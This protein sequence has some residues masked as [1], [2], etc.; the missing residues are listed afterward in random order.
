MGFFRS[1]N[2]PGIEKTPDTFLHL[3]NA[4]KLARISCTLKLDACKVLQAPAAFL[5]PANVLALTAPFQDLTLTL[6]IATIA[7]SL[8]N[9][10]RPLNSHLGDDLQAGPSHKRHSGL[11]GAGEEGLQSLTDADALWEVDGQ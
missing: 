8:T 3:P 7:A 9:P 4:Q 2:I 11:E 5:S 6:T 1:V 10:L